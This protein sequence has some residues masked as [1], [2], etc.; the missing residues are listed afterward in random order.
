MKT[1][2]Q[3]HQANSSDVK[4]LNKKIVVFSWKETWA[5]LTKCRPMIRLSD[6]C[7]TSIKIQQQS[8]KLNDSQTLTI[9]ITCQ[10]LAETKIG[11]I[12]LGK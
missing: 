9:V 7:N 3:W 12:A 1:L 10:L 4:K 11:N 6:K 8:D 5:I 2:K